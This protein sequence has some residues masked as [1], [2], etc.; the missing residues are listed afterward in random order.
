MGSSLLAHL[1]ATLPA[2]TVYRIVVLAANE[3]GLASWTLGF[4]AVSEIDGIEHF[5][6]HRGVA[7]NEAARPETMLVMERRIGHHDA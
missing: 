4:H 3:R 1:E 5:G 2:G 6:A 7:F